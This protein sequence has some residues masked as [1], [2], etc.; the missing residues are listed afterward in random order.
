VYQVTVDK[1]EIIQR[2]TESDPVGFDPESATFL[3]CDLKV[4]P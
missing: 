3:L 4:S 1:A 2:T